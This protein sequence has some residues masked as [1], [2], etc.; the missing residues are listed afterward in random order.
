MKAMTVV[1]NSFAKLWD[2]TPAIMKMEKL[3]H[4]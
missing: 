4:S 1:W 3:L 2:T